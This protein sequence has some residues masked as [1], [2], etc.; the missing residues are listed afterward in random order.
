MLYTSEINGAV[1]QGFFFFF[2]FTS[3]THSSDLTPLFLY[4]VYSTLNV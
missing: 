2:V 4:L 1:Y 3:I